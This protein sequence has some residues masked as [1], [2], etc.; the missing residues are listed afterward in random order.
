MNELVT[1]ELCYIG[2]CLLLGAGLMLLYDI[3][4]IIR[5]VIPHSIVV[6]SIED[7]LYWIAAGIFM[8]MLLYKED[9]GSI[10]WF[11]VV[12]AVSGMLIYNFGI[13]RLAVPFVGKCIRWPLLQ[14]VRGLRLVTCKMG[15]TGKKVTGLLKKLIKKDRIEKR[16]KESGSEK[17]EIN[18]REGT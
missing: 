16:L 5:I 9:A 18:G 2:E 15:A 13:S 3:L 4:R 17:G 1:W 7:V 10:R 14:I 11:A 12:I 6:I 8:F